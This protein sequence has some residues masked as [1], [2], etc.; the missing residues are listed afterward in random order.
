MNNLN[1]LC[2]FALYIIDIIIWLDQP[3]GFIKW[4]NDHNKN[5]CALDSIDI[6]DILALLILIFLANI[7]WRIVIW[8]EKVQKYDEQFQD[9]LEE[10]KEF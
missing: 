9:I 5:P 3:I 1:P 10:I 6:Q 7:G 4:V 8:R 2:K